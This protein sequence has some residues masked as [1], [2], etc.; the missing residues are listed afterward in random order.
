MKIRKELEERIDAYP[1]MFDM[2]AKGIAVVFEFFSILWAR[3]R[4]KKRAQVVP[5]K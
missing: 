5:I 3:A 4:G 2:R 1:P